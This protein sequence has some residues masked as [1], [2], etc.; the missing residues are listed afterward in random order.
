MALMLRGWTDD[1]VLLTN[2][3]SG[4]EPDQ[5]EQLGAVGVTIDERKITEFVSES[6]ELAAVEFAEGPPLA[7]RGV[8]VAASLRQSSTL[9]AQLGVAVLP[10]SP[11]IVDGIEVD[12]FYRTSVPG[13]FAAGDVSAAIPQVAGAVAAGSMA[14]TAAVQSLLA[15]DFGLPIPP[16]PIKKENVN[17]HA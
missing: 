16:W 12:P 9:A 11:V 7:R 14:A 2:G 3:E 6:G 8:L 10:P 13:V 17:A 15:D 1:I 4:L 5:V